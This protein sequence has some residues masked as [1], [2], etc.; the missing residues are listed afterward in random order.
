MRNLSCTENILLLAFSLRADST[1]GKHIV[2]AT[3]HNIICCMRQHFISV[4]FWVARSPYHLCIV[5]CRLTYKSQCIVFSVKFTS[6]IKRSLRLNLM[7]A[8]PTSDFIVVSRKA[9]LL[10]VTATS[11]LCYQINAEAR[12]AQK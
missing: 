6:R 3:P 5:C 8:I 4:A 2:C 11:F 1:L 12:T 9:M 7:I 10:A